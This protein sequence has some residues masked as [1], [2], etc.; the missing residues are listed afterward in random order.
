LAGV[1]SACTGTRTLSPNAT[2]PAPACSPPQAFRVADLDL[3]KDKT[4]GGNA[5]NLAP[6]AAGLDA[7]ALH[8]LDS[9]WQGAD[10]DADLDAQYGGAAGAGLLQGA[11]GNDLLFGA[12]D[13]MDMYGAGEFTEAREQPRE[14]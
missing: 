3:P 7:S 14:F 2:A 6:G 13:G 12:G 11:G 4:T 10:L 5:I 8:D 1:R 9:A